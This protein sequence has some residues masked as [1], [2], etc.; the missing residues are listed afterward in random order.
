MNTNQY[1][2][3]AWS[4]YIWIAGASASELADIR[5]RQVN[6]LGRM[7]GRGFEFKREASL[8][9]LTNELVKPSPD[10]GKARF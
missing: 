8:S 2:L 5:Y 6:L 4:S 10:D 3:K 7:E 9:T 1:I